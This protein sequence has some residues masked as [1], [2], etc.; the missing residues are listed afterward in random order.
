MIIIMEFPD[1]PKPAEH[2]FEFFGLVEGAVGRVP[3]TI[4]ANP[5]PSVVWTIGGETILENSHE[6]RYTVE[7]TVSKVTLRF[8]T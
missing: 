7:A 2:A 8:I 6:G 4:E 5:K 1:P 3:V